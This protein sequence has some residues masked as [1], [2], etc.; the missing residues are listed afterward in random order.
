MESPPCL[1]QKHHC[2]RKEREKRRPVEKGGER[3]KIV[4]EEAVQLRREDLEQS[5]AGVK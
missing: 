4:K 3:P 1:A 2:Q 5:K